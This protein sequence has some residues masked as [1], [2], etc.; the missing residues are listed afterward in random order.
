LQSPEVVRS[1]RMDAVDAIRLLR[2][3]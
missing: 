3:K 2:Q 1:V